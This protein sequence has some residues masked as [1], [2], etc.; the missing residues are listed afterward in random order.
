[1]SAAATG[2]AAGA[3]AIFGMATSYFGQKSR[4][5]DADKFNKAMRNN[6]VTGL[7]YQNRGATTQQAQME[8]QIAEQ[9][10]STKKEM[11]KAIGAAKARNAERGV[12]GSSDRVI[13]GVIE[14]GSRALAILD[15]NL[16]ESQATY[17]QTIEGNQFTAKSKIESQTLQPRFS[18]LN[19][20]KEGISGAASG[21]SIANG[22]SSAAPSGG[23]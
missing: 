7:M 19:V 5:K 17:Q 13:Q 11:I 15:D 3:G 20:I 9:K 8:K 16:K 10:L 4:M 23:A 14:D 6:E 18:W 2:A 22:M 1:M 21:A 12:S